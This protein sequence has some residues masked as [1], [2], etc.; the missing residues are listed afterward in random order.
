MRRSLSLSSLPLIR[1]RLV[2]SAQASEEDIK[3]DIE[4][5]ERDVEEEAEEVEK[6]VILLNCTQVSLVDAP[7]MLQEPD[8]AEK[9]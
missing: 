1:Q 3:E 2:V 5:E 6:L 4:I 7:E 9:S 8:E